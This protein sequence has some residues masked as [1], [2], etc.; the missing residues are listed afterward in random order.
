MSS[1]GISTTR[2]DSLRARIRPRMLVICAVVWVL[3]WGDLSV[4]NLLAGAFLG[5]LIGLVFPLPPIAVDGR[6]HP[7]GLVMLVGR[8]AVDLVRSSVATTITVFRFGYTPR[9]AVITVQLASRSDLYLTQTAELVSL[10]PGSLVLEAR[11]S[12]STLSL[13][14]MDVRGPADLDRARA[15]VLAAE[16][17]V[18]RALGSRAEIEALRRGEPL[19]IEK[20]E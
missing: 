17:R 19:P 6:L 2:K 20:A 4:A 15:D 13:H 14:V 1:G 18:I 9:N 8:L 11:R 3:L 16:R 7:V 12:C 10:V 5:L